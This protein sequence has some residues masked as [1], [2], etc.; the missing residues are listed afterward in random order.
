MKNELQYAWEHTGCKFYAAGV[1]ALFRR[2]RAACGEA[3]PDGM[4]KQSA[5]LLYLQDGSVEV[6]IAGYPSVA[7]GAGCLFLLPRGY[8]YDGR[9]QENSVLWTCVV[10]SHIPLCD[11]YE[12]T[13][14]QQDIIHRGG[15]RDKAF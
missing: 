2:R 11:C 1:K 9:V 14:I 13:D 3:L 15:G 10:P 4:N 8:A 12:L 7:I 6:G 5:V